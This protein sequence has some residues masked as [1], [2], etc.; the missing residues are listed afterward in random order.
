V[1]LVLLLPRWSEA[2]AIFAT[3]ETGKFVFLYA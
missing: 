2:S 3:V 1:L